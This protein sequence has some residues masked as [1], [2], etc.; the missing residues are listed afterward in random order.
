[1]G[2]SLWREDGSDLYNCCCRSPAQSFSGL[3]PVRFVTIFH[4]LKFDTSIFV[5][6]YDSQGYCGGS[7]PHFHIA[8]LLPIGDTR[9]RHRLEG[10]HYCV[11]RVLYLGN[12]LVFSNLLPGNDPFIAI[13]SAGT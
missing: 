7:G 4:F 3:N 12:Y 11:S 13:V 10:F 2:R 9:R 5:A 6:F 8:F 1:V